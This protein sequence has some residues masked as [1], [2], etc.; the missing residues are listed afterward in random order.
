MLCLFSKGVWSISPIKLNWRSYVRI[1]YLEN[2][3][4]NI[5]SPKGSV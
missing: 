4:L 1:M 3:N 5:F 2:I